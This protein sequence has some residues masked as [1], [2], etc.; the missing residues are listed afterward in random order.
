MD[1]TRRI[2]SPMAHAS[3]PDLIVVPSPRPSPARA[4]FDKIL[5]GSGLDTHRLLDE[6]VEEFPAMPRPSTIE[7]ER[8]LIEVVVEM[9]GAHGALVRSQQPPL[10]ERHDQMHSRQHPRGSYLVAGDAAIAAAARA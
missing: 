2:L 1:S 5:I 10:E 3:G 4:V 7:A 9:R 8:K 6:P